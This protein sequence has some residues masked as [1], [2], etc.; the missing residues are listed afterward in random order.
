[1]NSSTVLPSPGVHEESSIL[2]GLAK[3]SCNETPSLSVE[4]TIWSQSLSIAYDHCPFASAK[5][6]VWFVCSVGSEFIITLNFCFVANHYL[7]SSIPAQ[8]ERGL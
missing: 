5:T 3:N 7:H 6:V 4:E 2:I 1:M 8:G